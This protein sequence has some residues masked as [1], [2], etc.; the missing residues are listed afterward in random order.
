MFNTSRIALRRSLTILKR[1]TLT[2][3]PIKPLVATKRNFCTESI[4]T[5]KL[6]LG[7]LEKKMKLVYTCKV[8]QTRNSNMISKLSYK[9]GVIIVK[10]AGCDNNHLIAD[11]LGW[12]K[13]Q[14][15]NIEDLMKE[16]GED[17]RRVDE[18]LFVIDKS[19]EIK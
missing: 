19:E 15:T 3:T 2:R 11:N 9:Q 10:C 17:V 14:K 13:D 12:F 18:T 16:K 5:Q 8:C 7:E 4:E 1:M 6:K